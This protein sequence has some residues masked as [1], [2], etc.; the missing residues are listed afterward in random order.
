LK[1]LV[2]NCGSS[3][4]K[5]QLFDMENEQVMAKGLVERIGILGSVLTHQA[6]DK[7]KI[8]EIKI[9]NHEKA[10]SLV[11]EAIIDP[12]YGVLKSMDEI[13]AIGHR[14]LH[15]GEDYSDSVLMSADVMKSIRK[16]IELGPLHNPHN[17][18]GIEACRRLLPGVPQVCVFDTAFHQTM[19]PEACLYGIPYEYYQKYKI[20]KYGFHGTS[21]RFVSARAAQL[22]GCAVEGFKVITCHLGNG[23]SIA[24]VKDGQCVDT[25]MG[26]TPLEGLMMGTRSGDLDPT[27]VTFLMKK[28]GWSCDEAN[29]FFNKKC[30][31]LGLSGVSSDFRDIEAATAKG[32]KRAKLALD[33]FAYVVKKYIG[34]YIAVLNGVDALV[35]TAGLG[36]NSASM[37]EKICQDLD[38][39]GIKIDPEKNKVRG[40][41]ALVSAEASPVKVLVIPT[42]EELMIARDTYEIVQEN[43]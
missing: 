27:V 23:S 2:I 6:G 30:G 17:I 26:L 34:A 43:K 20:R 37:R 28:E 19:P 3:S 10:V 1:I 42:N 41:E 29:D 40:Q 11:M 9:P 5:Y 24:A 18:T 16:N 7:K 25:T 22:L 14:V 33:R 35:F 36:E 13:A 38:Y 15:A 31:V 32:N 12:E 21:H 39:L 4:L 8:R